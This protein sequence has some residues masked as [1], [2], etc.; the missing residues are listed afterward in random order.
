M[1]FSILIGTGVELL[2][3]IVLGLLFYSMVG[4]YTT[5]LFV[6]IQPLF[7]ILNGITTS[8][9]YLLFNG[10]DWVLLIFLS[11]AVAPIF[12]FCTFAIIDELEPGLILKHYGEKINLSNLFLIIISC[13]ILGT[14]IGALHGFTSDR[15]SIPIKINRVA[16]Y[17]P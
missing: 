4:K 1:L 15:I 14:S 11:A 8:R 10:S 17:V 2:I 7:S 3:Y 5:G 16:R 9:L 6:V 12:A 13:S